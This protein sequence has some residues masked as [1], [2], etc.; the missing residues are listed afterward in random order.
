MPFADIAGLR[1]NYD[2]SGAPKAPVVV[3]SN[4]LGT[5]FGMWDLQRPALEAK[6]RLLRYDT[7][8]QGRTSVTPGPYTIEILGRDVLGLLDH[9]KIDRVHF[10]GLSMGGMIGIWLGLNA[11]ERLGKLVLCNT[12][13][14]IGTA[15]AWDTRIENIRK[16]GMRSI[17]PAIIERW[18]TPEFLGRSPEMSACALRMLECA[19]A[20]GYIACCEAVRDYDARESVASIRVP[21]MVIGGA[22]DRA[23]PPSDTRALAEKIPGARY[24]ELEAS[25][26]SNIEAPER[27]TNE[28]TGFLSS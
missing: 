9:L 2:L 11:P 14:K 27:F 16:G 21:V 25:H 13:P 1:V 7:R 10:C 15:E 3:L 20:D 18:L 8:G 26:L 28:L 23:T 6:F 4:S 17:A 22:K 12:A 19:P 24:V 5:H